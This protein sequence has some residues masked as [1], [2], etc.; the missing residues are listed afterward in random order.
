MKFEGVP[1]CGT[2]S[3]GPQKD[4]P[5]SRRVPVVSRR[6]SPGNPTEPRQEGPAGDGPSPQ[7]PGRTW[8]NYEAGTIVPAEVLL[9]FIKVTG[10]NPM[11]LLQGKGRKYYPVIDDLL[12]GLT[13]MMTI[14]LKN[15]PKE[16]VSSSSR[17]TCIRGITIDGAGT[18]TKIQFLIK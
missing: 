17:S 16:T 8:D 10:V 1:A 15:P 18:N 4:R 12:S 5:T 3:S 6:S 14:V 9:R 7:S 11:W 2:E 13:P